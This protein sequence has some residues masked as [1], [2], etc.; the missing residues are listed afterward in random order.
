MYYVHICTCLWI[1]ILYRSMLW[2][3]V[4]VCVYMHVCVL[5]RIPSCIDLFPCHL[6]VSHVL[7]FYLY[8]YWINDFWFLISVARSQISHDDVIIWKRFPRCWPFVGGIHLSS[9][10]SLHR[11]Q[12]RGALILSFSAP[13]PTVQT[14]QTMEK[15]VFWDAIALIMTSL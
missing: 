14:E 12:W 7:I 9:V 11:G 10:N 3:R 8:T 5:I 15:Q 13:E 1:L 4:S 2:V 6:F